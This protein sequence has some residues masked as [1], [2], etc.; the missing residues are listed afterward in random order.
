MENMF[1]DFA[2]SLVFHSCVSQSVFYRFFLRSLAPCTCPLVCGF[3]F[4]YIIGINAELAK[5][6][7]AN[8]SVGG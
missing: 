5:T 4:V 6:S 3:P 8:P 7:K 2:L 1:T